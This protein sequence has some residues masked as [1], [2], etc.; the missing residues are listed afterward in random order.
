MI[1]N[2]IIKAETLIKSGNCSRLIL[3]AMW[4]HVNIDPDHDPHI[5][6]KNL[7]FH[8]EDRGVVT[9]ICNPSTGDAEAGGS[10]SS[11]PAWSTKRVLGQSGLHSKKN[12]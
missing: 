5:Q 9:H 4:S 11:R 6:Q 8:L 2:K 12:L 1:K 7:L 3:H 10:L